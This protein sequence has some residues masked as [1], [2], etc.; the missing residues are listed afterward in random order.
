MSTVYLRPGGTYLKDPAESR[1]IGFDWDIDGNLAAAVTITSSTW[2]I[3]AIRPSTDTALT[4]DNPSI[5]SGSRKTQVRLIAGTLGASYDLINTI[6]TS[7]SPTQ[8]KE[9]SVRIQ[10]ENL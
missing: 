7:E 5:L 9:R 6:V 4:K 10:V 2:T 1:I 3:T 8:T